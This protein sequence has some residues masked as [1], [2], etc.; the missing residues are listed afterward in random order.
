MSFGYS[1][2]DVVFLSNLAWKTYNSCKEAPD[3]FANVRQE[4]LSLHAVLKET[5]E[6]LSECNLTPAQQQRLHT[7]CDGCK[8]VLEDLDG[9]IQKYQNL[10]TNSQR[11]WDR[12]KWGME[13]TNDLRNRLVSNTTL[14]SGF[15]LYGLYFRTLRDP[16]LN[17]V[18]G[19]RRLSLSRNF[20]SYSPNFNKGDER[21]HFSRYRPSTLYL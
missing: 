21:F 16:L 12:L 18:T 11:T 8:S 1:I 17:K 13:N 7:L 9:L 3:S 10:G 15:L 20:G 5:E 19:V 14:L 6:V 2:S 4:T